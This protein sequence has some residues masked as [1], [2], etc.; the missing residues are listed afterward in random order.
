M[1]HRKPVVK[2]FVLAVGEI[3]LRNSIDSGSIDID[4]YVLVQLGQIHGVPPAST[5]T[6]I[7]AVSLHF[8]RSRMAICVY[9]PLAHH[10]LTC[11]ISSHAYSVRHV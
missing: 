10:F 9:R 11:I 4:N 8:T 3:W 6:D 7:V 1:L 5:L 2:N